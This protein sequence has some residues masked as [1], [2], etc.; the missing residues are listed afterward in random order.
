[1]MPENIYRDWM[2][3]FSNPNLKIEDTLLYQVLHSAKPLKWDRWNAVFIID[4]DNPIVSIFGNTQ[5]SGLNRSLTDAESK[6]VDWAYYIL[7][8]NAAELRRVSIKGN[9]YDKKN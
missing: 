5:M 6:L 2:A 9:N 7:N 3:Q 1:M 4:G 8:K